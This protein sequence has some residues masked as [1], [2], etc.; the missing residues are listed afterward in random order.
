MGKAQD[1]GEPFARLIQFH[2]VADGAHMRVETAAE[3][4][5]AVRRGNHFR[6]GKT[7]LKRHDQPMSGRRQT[8]NAKP[9]NRKRDKNPPRPGKAHIEEH[10]AKRRQEEKQ[11]R[12]RN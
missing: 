10:N 2:R 6:G 1:F 11:V 4:D 8:Q 3:H 12:W 9:Q 5:N 7:L